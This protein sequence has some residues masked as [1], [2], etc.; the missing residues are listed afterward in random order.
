MLDA[1]KEVIGK[2]DTHGRVRS[3]VGNMRTYRLWLDA[4]QY[5]KDQTQILERKSEDLYQTFNLLVRRRPEE[6]NFKAVLQTIRDLM[7]T[8]R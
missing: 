3:A 6:N 8:E 2:R 4:A 7:L 1:D 5:Q